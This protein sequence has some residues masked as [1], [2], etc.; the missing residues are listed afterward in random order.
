VNGATVSELGSRADRRRDTITLDGERI[1]EQEKLYVVLNKPRGYLCTSADRWGRKTVLELLGGIRQRLFTVGRLDRDA[2]GLLLLTNDG[3]FAQR[4]AH[5]RGKIGK[6]YQLEVK[7]KLSSE[8]RRRLERGIVLDGKKTLPSSIIEVRQAGDRQ[9]VTMKIWEGRKRQLKRMF[10]AVGCPVKRLRRV[11]IGGL[12]LGD[13]SPGK[14]RRAG[15]KEMETVFADESASPGRR[16]PRRAMASAAGTGAR[17]MAFAIALPCLIAGTATGQ[18]RFPCAGEINTDSVNLRAGKSLNYEVVEKLDNGDRVTVCGISDGWYRVMPPAGV[19][20][21]VASRYVEDGRVA[22][23]RLNV[24]AKPTTSSTVV[25][26]LSRGDRVEVAET[27]DDWTAIEAPAAASCWVSAE[28][29]DLL[30]DEKAKEKPAEQ[31]AEEG[32]EP[33]LGEQPIA[34]ASAEVEKKAIPCVFE[35]TLRRAEEPPAPNVRYCLVQ[36]ILF[37]KTVCLLASETI[38]IAYFEG[39]RVKVWGYELLRLPSGIPV[40]DVRRLEVQ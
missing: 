2:E 25:C 4:V 24:R 19:Q 22:C 6:I 12:H 5:P 16:R 26:Q 14:Y 23:G 29:I 17:C 32:E 37:R 20:L 3:E 38:N 18:V 21:W 34:T 15:R 8:A 1:G 35:G 10:L 13:L 28:L 9:R 31:V 30:P 39:D 33:E 40:V 11:A 36:G 27:R 7:G